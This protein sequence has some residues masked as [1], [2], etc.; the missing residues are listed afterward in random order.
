M[1]IIIFF[2]SFFSLTRIKYSSTY[3][4]FVYY[5][6]TGAVWK[7]LQ[8]AKNLHN[9]DNRVRTVDISP[10]VISTDALYGSLHPTTREWKDGLFSST[11]RDLGRIENEHPKWIVL[12]G[13]VDAVRTVFIFLLVFVILS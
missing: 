13:D 5:L 12:D 7:V 1:Y 6:I 2:F 3:F 9:P 8:S 10:K 11:L 4:I